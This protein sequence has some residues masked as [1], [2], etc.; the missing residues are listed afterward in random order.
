M[1]FL[2]RIVSARHVDPPHH[3]VG[4]RDHFR[5]AQGEVLVDETINRL[6]YFGVRLDASRMRAALHARALLLFR[7]GDL[8]AAREKFAAL[9][10]TTPKS[11]RENY[12]NALS[13]FTAVRV[14]LHQVLA[15]L[16]EAAQREAWTADLV[17]DLARYVDR[18]TRQRPFDFVPPMPLADM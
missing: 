15:Y 9:L 1:S 6:F 5:A 2:R 13:N 4:T 7:S 8:R 11:D 12:L 16:R 10:E 18:I 3:P 14:E 17:A